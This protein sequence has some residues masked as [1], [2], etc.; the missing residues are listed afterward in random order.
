MWWDPRLEKFVC[1]EAHSHF[2]QKVKIRV[3]SKA[4][5]VVQLL[6]HKIYCKYQTPATLKAAT[7]RSR[8]VEKKGVSQSKSLLQKSP[9]VRAWL[10]LHYSSPNSRGHAAWPPHLII[11]L[12]TLSFRTK[13]Q[14]HHHLL[15]AIL[16]LLPF[17]AARA[18]RGVRCTGGGLSCFLFAGINLTDFLFIFSE[19]SGANPPHLRESPSHSWHLPARSLAGLV[20]AHRAGEACGLM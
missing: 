14:I 12:Q 4:S 10:L 11:L 15:S 3:F 7:V 6:W 5:W 20:G 1:T 8:N 16:W 13:V 19:L 9:E 2:V 17:V 18:R